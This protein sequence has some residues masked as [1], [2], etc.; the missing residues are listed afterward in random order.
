MMVIAESLDSTMVEARARKNL[1]LYSKKY[2][3][4]GN[5]DRVFLMTQDTEDFTDC[6]SGIV[7]VP[8]AFSQSRLIRCILSR[9]TYIRWLYFFLYSFLWLTKHRKNVNLVIS[10][11]V[12]SVSLPIFSMLFGIPYIVCYQYDIAYQLTE[13]N[14]RPLIGRLL[15]GVEGFAFRKAR[16][17]W[18]ASPSLIAKARRLGAR[19]VLVVPNWY[20]LYWDEIQ[21]DRMDALAEK[22]AAEFQV[23]FVGRLHPVKQVDLLL[24]AFGKLQKRIPNVNMCVLGDGIERKNLT[25]L[26][27]ALGLSDKVHFLGFVDRKTVFEM[28]RR[29]NVLALPSKVEGNPRVLIEAMIHRV[30]IVATN[31]PGIRDMVEH[32]ERGYLVGHSDPEELARGIEYVLRNEEVAASMATRAYAYAKEI[33]SRER[34]MRIISAELESIVPT[35]RSRPA[36]Y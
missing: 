9:F 24:K 2:E 35:Y 23:L 12:D 33:F 31:V 27:S 21:V 13:I 5:F 26:A 29:S 17:V 11:N 8:C 6:L 1:D 16:S 36:A 10:E 18:V 30:P 7:H 14:R 22:A 28:M 15:L 4:L 34:I 19:R 32:G 3:L 25:A 20:V